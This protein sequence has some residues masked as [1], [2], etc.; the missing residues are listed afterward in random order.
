MAH[1]RIFL[2]VLAFAAPCL[3]VSGQDAP[4]LEVEWLYHG[5]DQGGSRYSP[6]TDI[7]ASNVGQLEVAWEWQHWE[8]ALEEWGTTPGFFESTPLMIDGVL[9]VTTPYNNVAALDAETGE[10]LWRFDGE[11]Y[12]LG[13]LL[14]A[15]GFKLRGT[16]FWRN[17][18]RLYIFLNSRTRLFLLDAYTGEAV[19]SLWR[20]GRGFADR[21]VGT[22][23][24]H[25]PRQS[26]FASGD[27]WRSRDRWESDS[28]SRSDTGSDGVCPGVRRAY[29]RTRLDVLGN[30]GIRG[31]IPVRIPGRTSLGA[32]T[33][34]ETFGRR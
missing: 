11:G 25:C 24:R 14:S 22:H 34:T 28:G 7:D 17:E 32:R 16:A 3:L 10:E 8:T 6:L 21:W 19:Q 33:D 18:G 1:Q 23:R 2:L 31:T 4:N 5:G 9:Y 26:E 15:S 27:I 30:S 13:Q 29:G 20:Q 12:K